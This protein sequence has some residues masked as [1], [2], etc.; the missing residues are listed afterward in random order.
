M[1]IYRGNIVYSKDRETLAVHRDSCIA[2]ENGTVEGIYASLP[3]RYAGAPLTDYGDSVLIL[4]FSDLHVHAPKYP[5][6]GLGMD[7]LLADWLNTYTFPQESKFADPAYAETVYEAFVQSLIENGT[8]HACVFATIHRE[9]TSRLLERMEERKLRAYVGK[10]NMDIQSPEYLCETAE[11]S[12]YETEA[13]LEQYAGNRYAKPIITPRFAPTCSFELLKGLG[14]LGRKYGTGMQTH[15]VESR[16]EAAEAVRLNPECSCDTE[17]YEKAGLLEN[18]PA[19][20]AHFIFPTEDDIRILKKHGGY[21][22]QCPDATVN[23]IAG[24]MKTAALGDAGINLALGSDIAGGHLP[25]IYTQAA[26]S[27]QLSKLKAFYE[28]EEN[29]SIPFAEAF[30]MATKAGGKLFG[31]VGS[32]EPGYAF[33]ALVIRD[34]SDQFRKITPDETVERFCYTGNPSDITARFIDGENMNTKGNKAGGTDP[35]PAGLR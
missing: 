1:H 19:V 9:T 29:R 34:F 32:L 26:R 25:G 2:V 30:Y 3:E 10:V 4:A 14:K 23:V 15:L 17:I 8:F 6:R 16:W 27:V 20:A 33:D 11:E 7:L 35:E 31:K 28:P 18:G 12:L 24:I 22:V 13:F 5:Q 21:A